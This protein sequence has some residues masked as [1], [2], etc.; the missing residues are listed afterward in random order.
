M[1]IAICLSSA[2]QNYLHANSGG[3]IILTGTKVELGDRIKGGICP[4]KG[5]QYFDCNDQD[6]QYFYGRT[7]L[8]DQLLEK[9][10]QGNCLAVLGASGSGKSSVVRAGL[11]YQLKLGRR[12]SGSDRTSIHIFRPGDRPL[13]KLALEFVDSQ[14]SSVERAIQL[15]KAEELIVRGA[16]GLGHLVTADPNRVVLVVDQFEEVFTLCQDNNERQRFLECILGALQPLDKKFCLVISMR[17]DFFGKCAEQE[18]AGLA[19]TIQEHLVTVTPM[20][21][22]ELEQ[23]II[24]PA[25]KVGLEVERELIT[26]MIAD[27]KDSPGSLPLLEYTLT[28]LWQQRTVE[29]LTLSAYTRLGRVKGTLQ[30]RATEVYESLLPQ[31]QQAAKGIF[32]ELTQLGEGTEDTR[33]QVL[34]R[35]LVTAEQSE[36]FVEQII[37]KLADA[38]L[39][40]TSELVEKGSPPKRVAVVDIAH[41]ALIR[42]WSLLRGWIEENRDKLRQKRKIEAAA[43]EWRDRTLSLSRERSERY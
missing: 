12:L 6:A 28:E 30:K 41:E 37:Q 1:A 17:A 13:Q 25:K 39:V 3:E 16:E 22:S 7:T 27:V 10:R 18:Y 40:V 19:A 14:A 4:Y 33:R 36:A 5:L 2:L 35:N 42:H 21:E 31:E 24:E 43:E 29:R 34:K 26:E 23:A 11:L 20:S 15:A 8:T 32:I 9:V 38:K